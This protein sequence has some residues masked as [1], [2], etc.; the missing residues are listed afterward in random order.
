MQIFPYS[1]T[2]VKKVST[3]GKRGKQVTRSE[4]AVRIFHFLVRSVCVL[5]QV[6]I[7]QV[8]A[9]GLREIKVLENTC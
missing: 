5:K 4:S 2:S 8:S 6:R 7:R 3:E 9:L 1:F